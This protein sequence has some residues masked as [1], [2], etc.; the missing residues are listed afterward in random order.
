[1]TEKISLVGSFDGW[2]LWEFAKGRKRSLVTALG[3]LLG[4][5]VTDD[6]MAA[7]AAGM[8]IEGIFAVADFYFT[9]VKLKK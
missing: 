2:D 5:Y 6:K 3:A 8:A 1:M 7:L 4:Y 9:N